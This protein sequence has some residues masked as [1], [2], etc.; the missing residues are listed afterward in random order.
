MELTK[1]PPQCLDS[2]QS[3]IGAMILDKEAI[4]IAI[5]IVSKHDFYK[6]S[7][8]EIFET[9]VSLFHEH[10]D[11]H[12]IDVT[13]LGSKLADNGIL[14]KVG[15]YSHLSLCIENCPTPRNARSYAERIAEKSASRQIIMACNKATNDCYFNASPTDVLAVTLAALNAIGDKVAQACLPENISFQPLDLLPVFLPG[16][17]DLLMGFYR[18]HIAILG[19]DYAQGKTS[20]AI[21]EALFLAKNDYKIL[22]FN[23][24]DHKAL[25]GSRFLCNYLGITQ[26]ELQQKSRQPSSEDYQRVLSAQKAIQAMPIY[27]HC[28]TGGLPLSTITKQAFS[29]SKSG[30]LDLLIIDC[31]NNITLEGRDASR[32]RTEQLEIISRKLGEIATVSSCA[33]LVI[34][35]LNRDGRL[36]DCGKLEYDAHQIFY[37]TGTATFD[38]SMAM[39]QLNKEI[40]IKKNEGSVCSIEAWFYHYGSFIER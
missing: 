28:Q 24:K 25:F 16:L 7:H 30:G 31:I 29:M 8:G 3:L 11:A 36:A 4:E 10:P 39:T 26:Q 38:A 5:S 32:P 17:N 22:A 6:D 1:L 19:A 35:E 15:G 33:I 40:I 20:F 9:I 18:G 2:E 21:D 23:G 14:E 34:A 37:I 13:M 12:E 27:W